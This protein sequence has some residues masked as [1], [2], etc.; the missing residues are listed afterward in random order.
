MV[1]AAS[2]SAP[3]VPPTSSSTTQMTRRSPRGGRQPERASGSGGDGLGRGLRL[4][5]Q[6]AAAPQLA[7]DP[8]RPD[9]GSCCQSSGVGED[10]VHM[11][12]VAQRPGHPSSPRRRATRF[13]PLLARRRRSSTSKPASRQVG[14]QP[15]LRP[16]ARSPGGLTVSKRTSC[17]RT[18]V[19][20]SPESI[21]YC[22]EM[23]DDPRYGRRVP[24]GWVLLA[25]LGP[26][27]LAAP[28][29]ARAPRC[30]STWTP[31]ND[32]AGTQ[33]QL[34]VWAP[35]RRVIRPT[36]P[37][38]RLSRARASPS[39][40]PCRWTLGANCRRPVASD[41]PPGRSARASRG[42]QQ[43]RRRSRWATATTGRRRGDARARPGRRAGGDAVDGE[44][45]TT[46]IWGRGRRA[47]AATPGPPSTTARGPAPPRR[48]L[49][50][51]DGNAS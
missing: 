51:A 17:C 39:T 25:T 42:G 40:T 18:R 27:A 38:R 29:A 21:F 3:S 50:V 14:G 35:P 9:Q 46:R 23:L 10:R 5:V 34:R 19:G 28:A 22:A 48:G 7:V 47:A 26:S 30:A 2:T 6:R 33:Q 16:R 41:P 20:F 31:P 44:R 37:R 32:R 43:R 24:A 49:R 12:Q 36:R 45:A 4:H 13:G 15:L 8:R 1:L 11:G